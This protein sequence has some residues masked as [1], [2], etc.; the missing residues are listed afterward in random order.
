MADIVK[1]IKQITGGSIIVGTLV[2]IL[3]HFYQIIFLKI[4]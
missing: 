4:N 3:V 2:L 1:I